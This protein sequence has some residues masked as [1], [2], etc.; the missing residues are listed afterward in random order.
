MAYT[1]RMYLSASLNSGHAFV[2]TR[3][4]I[5]EHVVNSYSTACACTCACAIACTH[6]R[7]HTHNKPANPAAALSYPSPATPVHTDEYTYGII[8]K[9]QSTAVCWSYGSC[10]ET[11]FLCYL[12]VD[13]SICRSILDRSISTYVQKFSPAANCH[14]SCTTRYQAYPSLRP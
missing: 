10:A 11:S 1:C 6:T 7:K 9:C 13:L 5:C 3:L 2:C 4:K 14:S 12:S 8:L